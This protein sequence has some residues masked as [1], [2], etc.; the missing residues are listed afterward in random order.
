MFTFHMPTKIYVGQNAVKSNA[1]A[2]IQG[3]KAFIVTGKSSGQLSGAIDDVTSVLS[4]NSIP[5][6]IYDKIENNP[7]IESVALG[8]AAARE[9]GADFI[10]GIGGG[11]PLD[12]AKAIAVYA[13]NEP[14]DGSDFELFDIFKGS[15]K[16]KP[17]PMSAIPTTAGTGSEVTPYSILTLH[18]IHNKKSFS[19]PDVFY[20]TA[21]IDGRYTVNMPLQIARNTA[22]DAMCHL[23]EGFTNKRSSPS[24]DYIALEG[25]RIIGKHMNSLKNGDLSID[26]CTELL[27]ASS[28]GGIVIS[29][30]GTTVV[31][32]MG[33]PLTYYKDIP[34]GM[35]NGLLLVE[36]LKH[37]DTILSQ[38]ISQ[39]LKALDINSLDDLA[40][41][42]K[43][44]LP[45]TVQFSEEEVTEWTKT[46]IQSK[47]VSVC[48]FDVTRE[49]EIEIYKN[50]ISFFGIKKP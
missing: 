23:L 43:D 31:H 17:L 22:V 19:S 14:V 2:L 26:D 32:S 7:T 21:F 30:T 12:A 36:Y 42:L 47:N 41:Y 28:L 35:A 10:I 45:C 34:H 49:L 27:W 38:K 37:T 3:T 5:Y 44:I 33:Y 18:T 50:S 20:K 9:F 15:Y 39:C 13:V 8:G 11:S 48:P 25:L 24:S 46:T 29:Q 40:S 6:L 16:N 1:E 4:E